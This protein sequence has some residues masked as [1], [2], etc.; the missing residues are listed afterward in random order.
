M[1]TYYSYKFPEI[2]QEEAKERGSFGLSCPSHAVYSTTTT[3][4]LPG[5]F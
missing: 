2:D 1:P 5:H 3:A 4:S